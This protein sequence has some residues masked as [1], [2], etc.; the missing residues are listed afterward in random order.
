MEAPLFNKPLPVLALRNLVLFP[1]TTVPIR[2]GRAQ[3][4][5]AIRTLRPENHPENSDR[6]LSSS[7]TGQLLAVLQK[8]EDQ[9]EHIAPDELHSIGVLCQ[10]ERVRGNEKDGFQL[11]VR[12]ME[13]VRA[14]HAYESQGSLF[15]TPEPLK[16]IRDADP[17][18]LRA[19][20]DSV[21]S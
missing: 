18:T 6:S 3:S 15:A 5:A 17:A 12:G 16:E 11:V 20:L 2:V 21:K 19:L 10:I 13:R 1:G 7:F 4:V 14:A 9:K 8:P